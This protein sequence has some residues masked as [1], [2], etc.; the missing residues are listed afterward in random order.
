MGGGVRGSS[1]RTMERG[2]DREDEGRIGGREG[3]RE[4]GRGCDQDVK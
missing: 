2:R 4:G 1:L 3:G